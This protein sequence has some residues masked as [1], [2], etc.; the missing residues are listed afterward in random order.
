[1]ET[2]FFRFYNTESNKENVVETC[3]LSIL[4]STILFLFFAL[5]FRFTIAQV[6]KY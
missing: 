4:W 5:I 6:F 2:V 1:M 3:M